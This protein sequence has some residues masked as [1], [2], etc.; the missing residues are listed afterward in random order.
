MAEKAARGAERVMAEYGDAIEQFA[1]RGFTRACFLGSET[2]HGCIHEG[3][4]KMQEMTAGLVASTFDSYLGL[5]RGPHVFVNAECI[6]VA[7]ISSRPSVRRYELDLLRE[8]RA[9]KQGC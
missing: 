5:R 1:R 2:R 7:S 4:L 8:L 6:V 9:K 3:R